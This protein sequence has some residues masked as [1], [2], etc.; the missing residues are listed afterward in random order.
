MKWLVIIACALMV[1]CASK[2]EE[3]KEEAKPVVP[4]ST[5]KK[6]PVAWVNGAEVYSEVEPQY[7]AG[8]L[9]KEKLIYRA[10]TANF[11][12]PMKWRFVAEGDPAIHKNLS[13][14]A[15]QITTQKTRRKVDVPKSMLGQQAFAYEVIKKKRRFS[16]R[17]EEPKEEVPPRWVAMIEIPSTLQLYP[18]ADGKV[19]VAARMTV[20][21]DKGSISEWVNFALLPNSNKT[22]SFT[23]RQTMVEY[24]GVPID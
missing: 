5:W 13:I 7:G 14:D 21:T 16:F 24:G 4:V 15:V 19:V 23:F 3:K 17:K 11:D 10:G 6:S 2:Q 22:K 20:E 9:E 18:K 8:A 12:G 1:S